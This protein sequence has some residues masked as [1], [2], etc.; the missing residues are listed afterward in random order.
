MSDKETVIVG[1]SVKR[2]DALGKV[3]G[4]TAYPSDIDI[5]GQL[6]LKI[7]F[8]ERAHARILGVDSQAALALDGCCFYLA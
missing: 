6:W 3:T 5:E 1:Q 7:K 8:S 2:I 4:E